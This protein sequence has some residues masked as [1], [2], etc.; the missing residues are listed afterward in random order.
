MPLCVLNWREW[1]SFRG[2]KVI[3]YTRPLR[4]GWPR[5]SGPGL[6]TVSVLG[7]IFLKAKKTSG[8]SSNWCW[9]VM[10]KI[11][12]ILLKGDFLLLPLAACISW[13]GR[14]WCVR[15]WRGMTTKCCSRRNRKSSPRSVG[16]T[17][18][19]GWS[20]SFSF[21]KNNEKKSEATLW[22]RHG[23]NIWQPSVQHQSKIHFEPLC[24]LH[25]HM[26]FLLKL[27]LIEWLHLKY[28]WWNRRNR[29]CK[30]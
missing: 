4:R 16:S 2:H 9:S 30:T 27:S 10:M 5:I 14:H 23:F 25:W 3:I 6:C 22:Q 24:L 21:S 28:C 11:S 18:P 19:H 1:S 15:V 20:L 8:S 26:A 7:F 29:A 17:P 12:N 13:P